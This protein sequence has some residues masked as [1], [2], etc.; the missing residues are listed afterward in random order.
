MIF[1]Y[2]PLILIS[3]LGYGFFVSK[4]IIKIDNI[5]LGYQGI[6]G[7]FSLI[8]ISYTSTQFLA[9]NVIFNT[10]ILII[11]LI[12]FFTFLKKNNSDQKDFKLLLYIFLISLI[13][14]C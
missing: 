2:Y 4:K 3:I 10:L 1:I 6:I 7:I 13:F 8:L 5:N 12:F 11:G 9:H 14:V